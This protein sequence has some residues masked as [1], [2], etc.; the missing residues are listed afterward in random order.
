M[1]QDLTRDKK[2]SVYVPGA[3]VSN[4]L[5]FFTGPLITCTCLN[6][7]SSILAILSNGLVIVSI[8]RSQRLQ[9][10]SYL[11]ISS[12]SVV[13]FLVGLIHLPFTCIRAILRVLNMAEDIYDSEIA[14]VSIAMYLTGISFAM[15]FLISIDRYLALSLK[16]RYRTTVTKKRVQGAMMFFW[17]TGIPL[18]WMALNAEG[19]KQRWQLIAFSLGAVGI[20]LIILFYTM[21]FVTLNRYSANQ[22]HSQSTNQASSSFDV[23]KYKKSLHTM[24]LILFCILLCYLPYITT[25]VVMAYTKSDKKLKIVILF[26]QFSMVLFGSNSIINPL[27]Y[28]MRFHD[29]RLACKE[30]ITRLMPLCRRTSVEQV[31]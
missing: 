15:S 27:I 7:C 1:A 16:H 29:V 18:T 22:T 11:L 6:S 5:D 4:N 19:V 21:S 14:S 26:N 20:T 23:A 8:L 25:V 9:T 31:H 3:F 10:P 30:T 28:V 12:L 13:D 17:I 2:G 24:L